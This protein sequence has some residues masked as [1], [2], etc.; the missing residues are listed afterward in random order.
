[1]FTFVLVMETKRGSP[2]ISYGHYQVQSLSSDQHQKP[3]E[4][5]AVVFAELITTHVEVQPISDDEE[6]DLPTEFADMLATVTELLDKSA[7]VKRLKDF[8]K[9]LSHP[10]TH[11]RYIDVK[12]YEHCNTPGEIIE[13]LYPQYINFMHTHLL[14]RIV[15]KFG[16][17]QS[18]ALVKQ[19]EDNFP[20]KKPLKRMGDPIS[21]EEMELCSGTK[22]IKV[23]YDG[24]VDTTTIADVEK[25]QQTIS[26]NTRIDESM[27]V[28]AN[29][30]EGC[31]VFTFLIPEIV[32]SAF[33][34]LDDDNQRDLA[35]RG[36]LRIEMEDIAIDLQSLQAETKTDTSLIQTKTDTLLE[37]P[38]TNTSSAVTKTDDIS[39]YTTSG[40]KRV[41]LI[42][43]SPKLTNY[44]SEFKQ[45]ISDVVTPLA[46]SVEASKLNEYLQS[47]SHMLYPEAKYI[48]PRFLK[49]A[50]SVPQIF[51]ALQPQIINF[52]NLGVLWKAADAFDINIMSVFQRYQ[53]RFPSHTKLSTLPDPL[54]EEAI[55]GLCGFQKLRIT[56]CGGSG[57]ELTLGDVH[58][59]R[60][61]VEKVTG[62]DQDFIIYA[63]WEGGF[64]THQ[65][66][67]LIPKSVS[68]IF[69][70]LCEEDLVMLA[71]KGFQRLEVDYDT[72]KD[73]IQELYREHPQAVVPIREDSRMRNKSFGLEH[74][75]SEDEIERMSKEQ[76]GH[77]NDLIASTPDG[78]LQEI[79]SNDF[80][81][82]FA[83][84]MGKMGRW[85]ELASYLG[86]NQ[87]D[88]EDLVEM[89]PEDEV[90]QKYVALLNW[91]CIDVNSATY[92]R[93]VECLL[94]HGHTDDAK[95]LL[96]HFQ[97]QQQQF[98][99]YSSL[100]LDVYAPLY[101]MQVMKS[102]KPKKFYDTAI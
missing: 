8:L 44:N 54:S 56:Q 20:R 57:I 37:D 82:E 38:K 42:H 83:K 41:P 64:I 76:L 74:F 61:V 90:E 85:K 86:I 50:E 3:V 9:F 102:K 93:L 53:S 78:K 28:Y 101:L 99:F 60:E 10:R 70:E 45:L 1:M 68:E 96:L 94:T 79:C 16:N 31:V 71:E 88:L 98:F 89:Y 65:F 46:E 58:I 69:G 23:K 62:I 34:D 21:N 51:T 25:V 29:Q 12:L 32:V 2:E 66:T 55:S 35:N 4:E 100:L 77:L 39:T 75:I 48:D 43:D 26:R 15:W 59:V 95:E 14:R 33:C 84:K 87:W 5:T 6:W 40:M 52:M 22:K 97:G 13:V 19:Y 63:Y 80:L 27:I 11:K 91:K 49:D 24:D 72:V 17:E 73:N 30:T 36:M 67:F 18:K 47:F 7:N 81:K 92:E